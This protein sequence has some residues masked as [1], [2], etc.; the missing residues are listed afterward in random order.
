[1][2]NVLVE[3]M[4]ANEKRKIQLL[5]NKARNLGMDTEGRGEGAVNEYSGNVWIF[6]L[7]YPFTLYIPPCSYDEIYA[8]WFNF[9]GGEHHEM[10]VQGKSL[11]QLIEWCISLQT[12]AEKE[13]G[14]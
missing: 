10:P 2:G 9:N 1:V 4:D 5:T 6:L 3:A 14:N 13:Y 12:E 11:D 8:S 7:E